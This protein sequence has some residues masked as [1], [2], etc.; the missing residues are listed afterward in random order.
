M[1]D[2]NLQDPKDEKKGEEPEKPRYPTVESGQTPAL[3]AGDEFAGWA[4][5]QSEKREGELEKPRSFVTEAGQASTL[6]AGDEFA[7]WAGFQSEKREG[8]PE[9]PRS[10]VTEAGQSSAQSTAETARLPRLKGKKKE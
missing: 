1:T 7:G 4:G 8:E 5:F 3:R 10:S 9:K 2:A 6:R